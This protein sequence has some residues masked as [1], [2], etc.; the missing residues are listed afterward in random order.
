MAMILHWYVYAKKT[1]TTVTWRGNKQ[2]RY[3]LVRLYSLLPYPPVSE[4]KDVCRTGQLAAYCNVPLNLH[5][6]AT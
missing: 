4:F 5:F 6:T 1:R 2:K 3:L